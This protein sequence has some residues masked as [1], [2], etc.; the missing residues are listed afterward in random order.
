ME[1]YPLFARAAIFSKPSMVLAL[2]VL[3]ILSLTTIMMRQRI[4]RGFVYLVTKRP[5]WI[6]GVAAALTLASLTTLPFIKVSTSR[7]NLMDEDNPY[8]RQLNAFLKEFGNTNPLIGVVEGG[9][10]DQRR[11][12]SDRLA[13][14]LRGEPDQ[15]KSVLHRI[16]LEQMKKQALL[17]VPLDTL[18]NFKSILRRQGL[19]DPKLV[20]RFIGIHDLNTLL[21]ALSETVKETMAKPDPI[22]LQSNAQGKG[23]EIIKQLFV[24]MERWLKN[25]KH[26]EIRGLQDLYLKRFNPK[27]AN[28]DPQGYLA[29]RKYKRLYLFIRPKTDSDETQYLVPIVN[30]ARA[31]A[32]EICAKVPGVQVKF[33][34]FPALVVDEMNII[35]RDMFKTT[36]IALVG[37]VLIFMLVFRVVRQTV[38]ANV[39]LLVGLL[40]TVAFTIIAYG[41]FNLITSLFAAVLL[42][43]GID[44][45]IHIIARF[46]EARGRGDTPEQA[47][48]HTIMGVGPGLLTG[49]LTTATAFY[50]TSISEFTA[51]AELG[52]IAGTGMLFMLLA[53]LTILPALLMLKPGPV[54]K[55]AKPGTGKKRAAAV[56]L[57]IRWP[58]A[59]LIVGAVVTVA[60]YAQEEPPLDFN[61]TSM[62]PKDTESKEALV[63]MISESDFKMEFI[64]IIVK[65]VDEARRMTKELRKLHSVDRVESVADVVPANQQKKLDIIK[66]FKKLF[67]GLGARWGKQ[68]PIDPVKLE[69]RLDEVEETFDEAGILARRHGRTAEYKQLQDLR[70][71]IARVRRL[72]VVPGSIPPKPRPGAEKRLEAFQSRLFGWLMKGLNLVVEMLNPK[73]ITAKTLPPFARDQYIG[74]DKGKY[75]VY[76][77]PKKSIY[78]RVFLG[79]F[80]K[81]T[82][83]VAKKSKRDTTG[84]PVTFYI[85]SRMIKEGIVTAAFLAALAIMLMLLLDF[86]QDKFTVLAL[87]PLAILSVWSYQMAGWTG[88]IGFMLVMLGGMAM[89]DGKAV[90]Y[91]LLAMIPLAMGAAWMLGMMRLFGIDYNLA[92]VVAIPLLMGIGVV[93]NVHIIHR[94]RQEGEVDVYA[95]VRHT[96]GAVFLAAT[97]TMI[98][99]GALAAGSH[100]GMTSM[101]KTMI[102][103]IT[104]CMITALVVL[105][106]MLRILPHV[107]K[108]EAAG[109]ATGPTRSR[110]IERLAA[111][112]EDQEAK[113]E[114]DKA[115]EKKEEEADAPT[116][117]ES[118]DKPGGSE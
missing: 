38:L 39:A 116:D 99:F 112:N 90:G 79:E 68:P 65:S 15:F 74:R 27:R 22:V 85:H 75:A 97:T 42:G 48:E 77:Y 95:A 72:I 30:R 32:R 103:G 117:A 17:Y 102:I 110:E 106:A 14:A 61:V 23:I 87:I 2:L 73:K 100:G 56:R 111:V 63:K 60:A 114:E 80:V 53:A 83:K 7:T 31:L 89:F 94:F 40:W 8:Q 12:V 18:K 1:L 34:G 28:M 43:L 69:E 3:L 24:E 96:G 70:K 71:Q 25:P 81:E 35:Q 115:P 26:N 101:G 91:M 20:K 88:A 108:A 55:L 52:V 57:L 107:R 9:T 46:N 82:T 37:I 49:A 21:S 59:I 98:G 62:M 41:G 93:Y 33:T 47:V 113:P 19:T 66:E 36:V 76:V 5:I 54:P 51:F 86:T 4:L 10:L 13:A 78:D 11:K 44:F 6:L 105:P 67:K 45:G 118:K 109:N 84:Y 58:L 64:G 92:N 29:D 50:T 104:T 16:P